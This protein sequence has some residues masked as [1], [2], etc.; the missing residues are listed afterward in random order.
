M[1]TGEHTTSEV[2]ALMGVSRATVY[3]AMQRANSR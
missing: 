1:R 3:R 2:A